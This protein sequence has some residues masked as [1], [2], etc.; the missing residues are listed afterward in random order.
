V[1]LDTDVTTEERQVSETLRKEEIDVDRD[2]R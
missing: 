1:R 2:A